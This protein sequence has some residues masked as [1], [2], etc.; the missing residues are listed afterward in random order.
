[1]A[2]R[3]RE[4]QFLLFAAVAVVILAFDQLY[5][6]PQS[7]KLSRLREDVKATEGKLVEVQLLTKTL[8]DLESGI[9]RLEAETTRL[10]EKALGPDGLNGFL[11]HLGKESHRL[12]MKILSLNPEM[13]FPPADAEK[14]GT[15]PYKKVRLKIMLHSRFDSLLEYLK[16]VEGLPFFVRVSQ[17]QVEREEKT[18]PLLKTTLVLTVY[19]FSPDG[20]E[21]R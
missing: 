16:S 21:T 9:A 18:Y 11:R 15:L 20:K 14:A 2:L 8:E 6:T 4:K 10:E 3:A 17:F 5:Y 12:Q 19:L 7:R 1:M 13:E